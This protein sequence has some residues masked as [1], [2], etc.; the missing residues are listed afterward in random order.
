VLLSGVKRKMIVVLEQRQSST[1]RYYM[2]VVRS[3]RYNKTSVDRAY[4]LSSFTREARYCFLEYTI[5]DARVY[6]C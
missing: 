6:A 4:R 1:M 2:L 5:R 3:A